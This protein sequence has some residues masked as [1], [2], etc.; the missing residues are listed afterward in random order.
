MSTASQLS[1]RGRAAAGAAGRAAGVRSAG[2]SSL[3]LTAWAA[4]VTRS[5]LVAASWVTRW[6]SAAQSCALASCWARWR[7]SSVRC[8]SAVANAS[9]SAA[10]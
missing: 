5:V 2:A 3:Q 8:R 7:A 9:R 1:L 10:R 6:R 4:A